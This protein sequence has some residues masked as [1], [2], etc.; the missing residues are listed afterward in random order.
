MLLYF[1]IYEFYYN[2]DCFHLCSIGYAY[3]DK[4]S[5]VI[6]SNGI[7]IKFDSIPF[8]LVPCNNVCIMN[9]TST[10]CV[11]LQKI[12][13]FLPDNCSICQLKEFIELVDCTFQYI[14]I[15]LLRYVYLA[16]DKFISTWLDLPRGEMK[17]LNEKVVVIISRHWFH[18]HHFITNTDFFSVA[19]I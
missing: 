12:I 17:L 18:D 5:Y 15:D 19:N 13:V 6:S 2:H 1:I 10:M 9:S 16:A 4:T 7:L 11:L 8:S 3:F 14:Y